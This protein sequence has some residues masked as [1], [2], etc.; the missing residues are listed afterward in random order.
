M[1]WRIAG[2][3]PGHY[4]LQLALGDEVVT[5][6]LVV[7]GE[8]EA[9]ARRSPIRAQPEFL[10]QLLYPAE[11]PI[12]RSSEIQRIEIDYPEAEVSI[13]GFELQWMIW[14]VLLSIAF[15]LMLRKRFDV[16]F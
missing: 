11:A 14:F 10:G 1:A 5:K 4:D 3:A 6:S 12:E 16:T 2:V 9:I 8:G 13:F 15:A 7:E